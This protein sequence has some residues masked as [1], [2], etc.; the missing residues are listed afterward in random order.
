MREPRE[1]VALLRLETA[2]V[3]FMQSDSGW[4]EV[5]GAY[6]S[7]VIGPSRST[8]AA[9]SGRPT[10]F[11]RCVVHRLADR[12]GIV[13]EAGSLVENSIRL[14]KL[15]TSTIPTKL[16]QDLESTDYALPSQ[17]SLA[18][19]LAQTSL[20][21]PKRKMKIM[22]RDG[23]KTPSKKKE[24][25]KVLLQKSSSVS[26]KEKAYAEA[27]ARIFADEQEAES[28]AVDAG[29]QSPPLRTVESNESTHSHSSQVEDGKAVYRNRQEEAADPD[30]RRG[31]VLY[32]S[33][34]IN[35]TNAPQV[36][37]APY[38]SAAYASPP[39]STAFPPLAAS[40]PAFYPSWSSGKQ[41]TPQQR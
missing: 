27:R 34:G 4:L 8:T 5:G 28:S 25:K 7:I 18:N 2:L 17:A 21:D 20:G 11:Q 41:P 3:E 23:S 13:R 29:P 9:G 33:Y 16:L 12:F 19:S 31:V 40:A 1:R 30:F 24:N 26:D 36:A 32:P 14:I 37:Y 39:P 10:S 22:K 6:H 38:G 35:Y 15:P